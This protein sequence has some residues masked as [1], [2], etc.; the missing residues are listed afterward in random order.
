MRTSRLE[1]LADGVFAIVMTLL[2]FDLRLPELGAVSDGDL[3]K[4]VLALA[5]NLLS[6]VV[7]FLVLGVYWVGH[8][9]QFQYIRRVDQNLLW[10]NIIF[11]MCISLVPF[12]AGLLGRHGNSQVGIIVYGGNLILVALA[13]FSMWWYATNRQR[14]VDADIDP[15]IVALGKRLSLIPPA[16]YAVAMLLSLVNTTLSILIY[17]FMLG[18]YILG[19]F[20]R[21]G[22]NDARYTLE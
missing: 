4:A 2:V 20:Y 13:H 16:F 19:L 9:S 11:L 6:F 22:S 12:S 5:P 15:G 17:A 18:P 7:S 1:T 14:L 21:A 8:H 3:W 10:L